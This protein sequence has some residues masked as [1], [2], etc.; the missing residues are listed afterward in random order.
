MIH[1]NFEILKET[2]NFSGVAVQFFNIPENHPVFDFLCTP[3]FF[4]TK[5]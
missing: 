2:N 1:K 5:V 4:V 3:I